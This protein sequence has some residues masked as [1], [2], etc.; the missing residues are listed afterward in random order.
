MLFQYFQRRLYVQY[1]SI[2]QTHIHYASTKKTNVEA[3][4]WHTKTTFFFF[5]LRPNNSVEHGIKFI[6]CEVVR[7]KVVKEV[8]D[9]KKTQ[10]PQV[11]QGADTARLQLHT[12]TQTH[13]PNLH[14]HSKN[15]SK[16]ISMPIYNR[17]KKNSRR[18][19]VV[20]L[21]PLSC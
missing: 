18:Y 6:S 17:G 13:T 11:L 12:H 21:F 19:I 15:I 2:T 5:Y 14:S 1:F 7:L 4:H 3:T 10:S 8:L 16:L 9:A 20:S